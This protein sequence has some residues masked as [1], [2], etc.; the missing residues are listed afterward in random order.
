MARANIDDGDIFIGEFASGAICSVQSSFVTVGNYPGIEVRV[1]G[2]EGAAI[3]RLVEESG[4]CETLKMARP[5]DVEFR[6]VEVP[7]R[8]YP[9]GGSPRES[10]RTLYYANLTANFA[11]EVLGEIDGNEGN[12]DDG[13]RVQE[14]INAVELS[15][16]ERRWVS[17]PLDAEDGAGAGGTAR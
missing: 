15:H 12:F 14:V 4:I 11:S 5:A 13:L 2:S 10:W 17:L 16:H 3:A 8:Y 9:P 7:A 1:Y 6:E